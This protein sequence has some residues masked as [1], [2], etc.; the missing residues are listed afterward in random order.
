MLHHRA[1][2]AAR[3]S[4]HSCG[5]ARGYNTRNALLEIQQT[6]LQN[7]S[8]HHYSELWR[9]KV[10]GG[11]GVQWPCALEDR[12]GPAKEIPDMPKGYGICFRPTGFQGLEPSPGADLCPS[13]DSWNKRNLNGC[14]AA[15]KTWTE[16]A[17]ILS[18]TDVLSF[19]RRRQQPPAQPRGRSAAAKTYASIVN[20]K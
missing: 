12:R 13:C 9:Q 15:A 19:E 2:E 10:H 5:Q 18:L 20:P 7:Y 6:A 4:C 3:P 1:W 11:H 17:W 8:L 14:F 16:Y